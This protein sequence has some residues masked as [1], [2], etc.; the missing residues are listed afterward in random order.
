MNDNT[1]IPI[2]TNTRTSTNTKHTGNA[3]TDNRTGT[4]TNA[5]NTDAATNANIQG[6]PSVNDGA[7]P[8]VVLRGDLKAHLSMQSPAWTLSRYVHTFQAMQS[9]YSAETAQIPPRLRTSASDGFQYCRYRNLILTDQTL[10]SLHPTASDISDLF[11][12]FAPASETLP[13]F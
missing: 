5:G 11:Y 12:K 13:N 4:N 9:Q 1:R 2:N 6:L 10:Y 8:T 7:D 3:D